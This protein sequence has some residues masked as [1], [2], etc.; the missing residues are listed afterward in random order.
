M[1]LTNSM[2]IIATSAVVYKPAG[3]A[4]TNKKERVNV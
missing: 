4:D 1:N 3:G 2:G